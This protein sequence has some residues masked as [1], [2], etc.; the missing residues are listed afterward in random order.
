MCRSWR[1]SDTGMALTGLTAGLDPLIGKIGKCLGPRALRG[2]ARPCK[3]PFMVQHCL[4]SYL[5]H[6]K[7]NQGQNLKVYKIM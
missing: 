4:V 7:R 2:P 6:T 5:V 3:G 1:S